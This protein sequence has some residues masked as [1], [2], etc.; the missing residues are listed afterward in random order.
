LL[1]G[2]SV[3]REAFARTVRL[4]ASANKRPSVLTALVEDDD[5]DALWEIEGATSSRL[6]AEDRGLEGVDA[7]EFVFGMPHAKFINAA[8]AY[9]RPR[10]LNRFNGPGRGAWYAALEVETAL[11]EVAFHMTE[12]LGRTGE[13][14]AVVEYI[15]LHASL[16]GEFV[17]L[18]QVPDHPCLGAEP[19]R[20]YP[21]GNAIADSVRA[22]GV[23]GIIYPSVR[24]PGG[25]CFAALLPH[26]VQSV[27]PGAYWRLEWSG[28]PEPAVATL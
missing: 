15:E 23:N 19:T 18:R 9:S 22:S 16:A 14:K 5:L 8:F 17:D 1:E 12:F 13:Y 26:A 7:K 27:A 21:V 4:A 28:Q 11:K 24:H 2:L 20:A 3:V 25:T 10:E 6:V